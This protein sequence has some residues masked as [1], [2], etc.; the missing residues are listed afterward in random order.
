[1][2]NGFM[3]F[4]QEWARH[5]GRFREGQDEPEYATWKT[6]LRCALN[7]AKDIQE[8]KD[9]SNLDSPDPYKVFVFLPKETK[10]TLN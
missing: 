1:M 7:K 4:L 9:Q 3:F 8:L 5:T 6:R 10:G 2:V